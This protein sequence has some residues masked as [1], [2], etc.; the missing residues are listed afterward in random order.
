MRVSVAGILEA[1]AGDGS[2]GR[3]NHPLPRGLKG[4]L[5]NAVPSAERC[6]Q[7]VCTCADYEAG[8]IRYYIHHNGKTALKG[9]RANGRRQTL[10]LRALPLVLGRFTGVFPLY[11]FTK[12]PNLLL[13]YTTRPRGSDA[14]LHVGNNYRFIAGF[15]RNWHM[16]WRLVI[17][18]SWESKTLTVP[19][20]RPRIGMN[21]AK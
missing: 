9:P 8:L 16:A 17:P 21:G 18:V 19:R 20:E 15:P 6:L 7:L 2:Q 14:T 11:I 13:W 5:V 12:E 10:M 3:R 4:R 1:P